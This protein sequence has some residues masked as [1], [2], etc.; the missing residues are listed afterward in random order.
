MSRA[1]HPNAKI[2]KKGLKRLMSVDLH[3]INDDKMWR[4]TIEKPLSWWNKQEHRINLC[5]CHCC[6]NPVIE[7]KFHGKWW[8]VADIAHYLIWDS[9]HNGALFYR[10]TL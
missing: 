10:D 4:T 8:S 5:D 1:V 3:R 9:K 6:D 2:I 7:Y